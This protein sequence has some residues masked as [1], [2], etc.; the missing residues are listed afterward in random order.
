MTDVKPGRPPKL[1]FVFAL[2]MMVVG[3]LMLRGRGDPDNPDVQCH[4]EN[5]PKV[6]GFGGATGLFSGFFG[7]GGGS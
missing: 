3:A 4:R 6:I 7:I 5:A 1:L 2:L